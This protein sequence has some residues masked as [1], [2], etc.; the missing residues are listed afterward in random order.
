VCDGA[1]NDCDGSVDEDIP[2]TP[3]TCG[4]GACAAT[5]TSSCVDGRLTDSC[6]AGTPSPEVCDGVDND[7]DGTVDGDSCGGTLEQCLACPADE[8]GKVTICHKP[9]ADG[10]G[11]TLEISRSALQA[12]CRK[13]GDTCGPC[14]GGDDGPPVSSNHGRRQGPRGGSVSLGQ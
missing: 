14:G 4:V 6:V 5:G 2:S 7:C 8:R 9:D 13:H 3:T 10:G 11:H 12:H 1:D